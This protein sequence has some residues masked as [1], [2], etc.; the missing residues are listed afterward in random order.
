M[1]VGWTAGCL[2][3]AGLGCRSAGGAGSGASNA[4]NVAAVTA[5][6]GGITA[7]NLAAGQCATDCP[8][9][10]HC[11]PRTGLCE[12]G[13]DDSPCGNMGCPRGKACD[14]SALLPQCVDESLLTG[15]LDTGRTF[16]PF[17]PFL[18]FAPFYY[19]PQ[20]QPYP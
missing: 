6:A 5:V 15:Q 9:D 13:H 2:L 10:T 16:K 1:R 12:R 17:R 20:V 18:P 3:L 8:P 14:N 19:W 4:L 11:S 7:L